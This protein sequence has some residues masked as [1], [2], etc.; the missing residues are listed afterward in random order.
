M[1]VLLHGQVQT[2]YQLTAWHRCTG[3]EQV[4][5]GN[6]VGFP[7]DLLGHV[8]CRD[9]GFILH[10]DGLT[11]AKAH[12]APVTAEILPA[13]SIGQ[14][15]L[16]AV[17]FALGCFLSVGECLFLGLKGC[18]IR[19]QILDSASDVLHLFGLCHAQGFQM[20]HVHDFAGLRVEAVQNLRVDLIQVHFFLHS[21]SA[22]GD[23]LHF[24]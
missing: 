10:A 4:R 8:L 2:L 19:F 24:A 16:Q 21:F 12:R 13:Q 6:F 5:N 23:V 3:L 7:R 20:V 15:A 17:D 9:G 14:V 22:G 11:A 18:G 1:P